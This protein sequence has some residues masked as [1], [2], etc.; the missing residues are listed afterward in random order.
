[1]KLYLI[2]VAWLSVIVL[3]I[4]I[5]PY[6]LFNRDQADEIGQRLKEVAKAIINL[7]PSSS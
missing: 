2:L 5:L 3:L 4:L 7:Q 1:M 6:A